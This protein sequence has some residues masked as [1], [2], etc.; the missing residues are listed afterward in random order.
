[1]VLDAHRQRDLCRTNVGGVCK[2]LWHR[3]NPILRMVVVNL[4]TA[5]FWSSIWTERWSIPSAI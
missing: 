4:E 5:T 2:D 3:E 1:V